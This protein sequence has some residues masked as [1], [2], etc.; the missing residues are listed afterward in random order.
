MPLQDLTPQLRTRLNHTERAVGWFVFL[1]TILLLFGFG[2][3]LY[4]AAERKGWFL[5]QAR[6]Y[7]YVNNA[8]DLKV[9]APVY[10]MGFEVGEVTGIV[11]EPPRTKHNVRIDFVVKQVNQTGKTPV[12]YFSYVWYQGSYVK[13]NSSGFLGKNG[14]EI[15]RGTNGY[16]IYITRPLQT[17]TLAEAAS[18]PDPANWRL[19]ENL[20]YP[21]TNVIAVPVFTS[22]TNFALIA[23][24]KPETLPA[25]HIVGKPRKHISAVWDDAAQR[26]RQYDE[27]NDDPTNAYELPVAESPALADQLQAVVAQVQQALPNVLA[28]TNKLG[29][30]LDNAA[31]ATSNLNLTIAATQPLV[32]NFT[33]IS[34]DLRGSGA[35][36]AWV[37]GTNGVFQLD[38]A[39]TNVNALLASTDT[40]LDQLTEQIG[41]TLINVA[42]ITSNLSVQV[43]AN[44]NLLWG[45]SKTIT[46]S[47]DFI[48]GLKRHWL[49]RS[50]FKTKATKQPAL[51]NPPPTQAK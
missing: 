19:A 34:G 17:L 28:L 16:S 50:A 44:S 1:A 29:I 26:Y 33:A 20:F 48:Q 38:G 4:H 15:T 47:D 49:L 31:N 11:A 14:L 39:L 27:H 24:L 18:V 42:D 8:T 37:V 2:Y 23:E 5:M 43:R 41:L 45:I 22:F 6:F 9:G 21:G 10:L 35:L 40:N 46:D 12:P 3:Y 32:H 13:V 51:K 30:V 7:T 25:V 36:G